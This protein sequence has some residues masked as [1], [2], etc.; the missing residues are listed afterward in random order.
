VGALTLPASGDVYLEA[1]A[2]I[3]AVGKME[4]YLDPASLLAWVLRQPLARC[5]R[6]IAWHGMT[7]SR[8]KGRR[9]IAPPAPS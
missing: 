4:P 6:R 1:N 7:Q 9:R 3:Y 2:V 5:L 8:N